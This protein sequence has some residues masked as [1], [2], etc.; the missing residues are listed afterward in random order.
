MTLPHVK[1][2]I[3]SD[4]NTVLKESQKCVVMTGF[5]NN[6]PHIKIH[7]RRNPGTGSTM[8]YTLIVYNPTADVDGMGVA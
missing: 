8:G 3:N 7:S 5:G 1:E 6:N 4:G 2:K